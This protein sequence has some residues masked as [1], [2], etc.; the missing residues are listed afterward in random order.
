MEPQKKLMLIEDDEDFRGL[1]AS[2]MKGIASEIFEASDGQRGLELIKK[3][4]PHVIISDYSMPKLNGLE[5]LKFLREQ[6]IYVPVIWLTGNGTQDLFREAWRFG[7]F[8][9]FEKPVDTQKL[10]ECVTVALSSGLEFNLQRK[11]SFLGR[12]HHKDIQLSIESD[13][14]EKF[15]SVCLSEGTSMTSLIHHLMSEEVEKKLP[16]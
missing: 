4:Q 11:P 15:V 16:K 13:L 6:K 3:C 5:L 8:D 14:Y 2:T 12:V 10:K 9:F 7:V 1:L